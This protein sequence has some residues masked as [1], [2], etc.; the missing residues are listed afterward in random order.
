M[1]ELP[2]VTIY[3]E[4]LAARTLGQPLERVLLKSPFLLRTVTPPLSATFGKV[5]T[6]V[7]RIGKRIVLGLEDDLFLVIHLMIAG[8]LRWKKKG[9][10]PPARNGLASFDFPTGTMV[11]TEASK[12]KRA[13]LHVVHGEE[14]LAAFD[15]GGVDPRTVTLDELEARMHGERH[16]LKRSLTDPRLFDGI[17]GAYADEILFRAKLSPVG[18]STSLDREALERLRVAMGEVMVEWIA[19]FREQVG[20]GFPDKVTAFQPEMAVHGKYGEACP[21]CGSPVQRIVYATRETNYCATC[22]T[23]GKLLRDRALSQLLKKDWPANLDE[24]EALKRR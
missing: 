24:L 7:R 15:R 8:R 2:D 19:R 11:F 3:C 16:T 13:K 1:P 12:K 20:D 5:V 17:G 4:R 23:D 22:Q 10:K 9:T 21:V 14:A 6:D 18:W